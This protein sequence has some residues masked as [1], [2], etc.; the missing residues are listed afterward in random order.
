MEEKRF[1]SPWGLAFCGLLILAAGALY[2]ILSL[3]PKGTKAI[4][5]LDGETVLEKDLSRLTESATFSL[6]GAGGIQ[7]SIEFSP[8]GA[9]VVSST[10]PDQVCVQTGKLTRA[11]ESAVC[12]PAK[13]SLRLEGSENPVDG[14]VY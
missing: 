2:L 6:E 10:C 7:V 1:L 5:E 8:Q 4:V 14:I 9:A 11:G 3:S 13:V 12:L